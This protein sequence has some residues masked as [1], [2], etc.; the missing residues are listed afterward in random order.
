M[1]QVGEIK[2][3]GSFD[4]NPPEIGLPEV[5]FV[6]RSNIGKSSLLNSLTSSKEAVVS[7]TPGRT[8]RV[9]L[10]AHRES[11]SRV[12]CLA[13]LPGFGYAE[14]GKSGQV[15]LN[16]DPISIDNIGIS[17]CEIKVDISELPNTEPCTLNQANISELLTTY[18][19]SRADLRLVVLLVDA[20]LDPQKADLEVMDILLDRCDSGRK[21]SPWAE[22]IARDNLW[23]QAREKI[24]INSNHLNGDVLHASWFV[25]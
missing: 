20:R 4:T 25:E 2:F 21:E 3:L 10:F 1:T 5:C 6:G 24:G 13:D 17:P 8:R 11:P 18:L 7:K 23:I 22:Q 14:I 12:L 9:N 15:R 16:S 19:S